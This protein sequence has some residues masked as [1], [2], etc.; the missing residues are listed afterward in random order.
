MTEMNPLKPPKAIPVR[1]ETPIATGVEA[2]ESSS[3]AQMTA[4]METMEPT[5]RS[6]P[7]ESMTRVMPNANT[8]IIAVWFAIFIKLP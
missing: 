7:P 4:E 3:R 2:P 1:M 6:I 8:L 5:E